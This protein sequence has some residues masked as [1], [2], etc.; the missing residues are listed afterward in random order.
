MFGDKPDQTWNVTSLLINVLC[1]GMVV[2]ERLRHLGMVDV[3]AYV[4]I[5]IN[6]LFY[7]I[8]HPVSYISLVCWGGGERRNLPPLEP[9]F[10]ILL[11]N[12][13][14]ALLVTIYHWTPNA[15]Y[16]GIIKNITRL[17]EKH[18]VFTIPCWKSH[19]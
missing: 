18:M 12:S 3:L 17:L 11:T 14:S 4:Y 16:R 13:S 2:F 6:I 7:V 1:L 19:F 9:I 10:V 8:R 5:Y 15:Y